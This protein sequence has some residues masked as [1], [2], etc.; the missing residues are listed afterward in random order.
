MPSQARTINYYVPSLSIYLIS[1]RQVIGCLLNG[2]PGT[3]FYLKSPIA[4][5]KLRLPLT[6]PSMIL[7]PL[8]IILYCSLFKD[9]L[10]SSDKAIDKLFFII[11]DLE[12][13]AFAI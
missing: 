12:S 4:R 13:P 6:L 9:G 8:W 7:P 5:V 2:M 1:G 10:W 11:T 3:A